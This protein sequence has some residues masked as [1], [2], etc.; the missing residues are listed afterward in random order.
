M[1]YELP[2][3]LSNNL[4]LRILAFSPMGGL[5]AH[6][7]KKKKKTEDLRKYGNIRKISNL[8]GYI[9]QCPVS[10]PEIKLWQ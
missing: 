10:P 2:Y 4:R 7:R 3:E 6:T 9:A 1:V 8:E 5:S